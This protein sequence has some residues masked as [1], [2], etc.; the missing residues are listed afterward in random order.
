MARSPRAP[1]NQ[2]F[3]CLS[4]LMFN[5]LHKDP[6]GADREPKRSLGTPQRPPTRDS[7]EAPSGSTRNPRDPYQGSPGPLERPKGHPE[8]PKPQQL[9]RPQRHL[10]SVWGA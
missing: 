1:G 9:S 3:W 5:I 10:E 2:R 4:L 6:L 7:S 8:K